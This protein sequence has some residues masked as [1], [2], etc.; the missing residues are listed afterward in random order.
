MNLKNIVKENNDLSSHNGLVMEY[1]RL[2]IQ[3]KQLQYMENKNS[4]Q[5]EQLNREQQ[6]LLDNIQTYFDLEVI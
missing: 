5:L 2:S 6:T 1:K 4:T 3:L